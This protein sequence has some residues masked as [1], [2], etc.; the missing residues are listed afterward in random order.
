[1]GL[2][3]DGMEMIRRVEAEK[4]GMEGFRD[5][6]EPAG[7]PIRGPGAEPRSFAVPKKGQACGYCG[8]IKGRPPS[9]DEMAAYDL[10][11]LVGEYLNG[12]DVDQTRAVARGMLM[13][14]TNP[15]AQQLGKMIIAMIDLGQKLGQMSAA[16]L[17]GGIWT[18]RE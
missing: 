13:V 4:Q 1:M 9:N 8:E 2:D 17:N 7:G 14:T 15:T 12:I 3:N 18:P 5:A 16:P 10:L 6:Q 11:D